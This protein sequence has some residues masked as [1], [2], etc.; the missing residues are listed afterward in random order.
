MD[1]L[2]KTPTENTIALRRGDFSTLADAL[3]YAA[4][5]ESGFNF[6]SGKGGLSSVLPYALLRRQAHALARRL[7]GLGLRR[8]ARFALVAE[9]EPDFVRFF[10]ACQYAGLIPVPLPA[11]VHLG[12]RQAMVEKLR[13]LIAACG[14]EAA[15]ATPSFA[16]FLAEAAAELRVKH[17]GEPGIFDDLPETDEPLHPLGPE[18]TAYLQYT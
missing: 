2:K 9:T 4:S 16:P 8:G 18:E 1:T 13:G 12:G 15:M 10:F 6:Y 3:D 17:V 11:A 5:G 7:R 14:A